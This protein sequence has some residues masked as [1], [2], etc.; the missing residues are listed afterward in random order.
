MKLTEAKN[1]SCKG[2][3]IKI[4]NL[5]HFHIYFKISYNFTIRVCFVFSV[6]CQNRVKI[7]I[8]RT[9]IRPIEDEDI[10]YF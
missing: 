6:P 8:L 5:I 7:M 10:L 1:D 3:I 4:V 2:K 9:L